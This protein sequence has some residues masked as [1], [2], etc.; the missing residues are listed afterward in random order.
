MG[1]DEGRIKANRREIIRLLHDHELGNAKIWH[2]K[3][4][5]NR[6]NDDPDFQKSLNKA[7]LKKVT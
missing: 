4:L 6:L 7:K 2:Y 3:E 5:A 1:R